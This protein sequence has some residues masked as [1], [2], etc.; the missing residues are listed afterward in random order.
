[1]NFAIIYI[2]LICDTIEKQEKDTINLM[3][4]QI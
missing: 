4:K 1:M 2:V 3:F